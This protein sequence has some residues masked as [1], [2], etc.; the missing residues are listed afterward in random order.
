MVRTVREP[1]PTTPQL[2]RVS[3]SSAS[4]SRR[5][6]G[7]SPQQPVFMRS[8]T[9]YHASSPKGNAVTTSIVTKKR[10]ILGEREENI[11]LSSPSRVQPLKSSLKMKKTSLTPRT[12][13]SKDN[14]TPELNNDLSGLSRFI[15]KSPSTN[16][17]LPTR[18]DIPSSSPMAP[19]SSFISRPGSTPY[20]PRMSM[21][22]RVNEDD[23]LLLNM[24]APDMAFS[25]PGYDLTD[26][27]DVEAPRGGMLRRGGLMTPANSQEVPSGSPQRAQTAKKTTA[28]SNVTRN[29][30]SRL[31]TPPSSQCGSQ[32]L[33][34]PPPTPQAGPSR[35]SRI[36]AR[37]SPTPP[38]RIS[39]EP[40]EVLRLGDI[41][42]EW[43]TP[44]RLGDDVSPNP[45]RKKSPRISQPGQTPTKQR[46]PS[47]P[48]SRVEV[49]IPTRSRSNTP[50]TTNEPPATVKPRVKGRA[51]SKTPSTSRRIS[52][53][54]SRK[55]SGDSTKTTASIA[56][57]AVSRS[58][59]SIP[60]TA[61]AGRRKFTPPNTT[62]RKTRTTPPSQANRRASVPANTKT[63]KGRGRK[64]I[65]QTPKDLALSGR[66]LGMLP[67]PIHG[68]PGD[69]PLLLK[70]RYS[71]DDRREG[72]RDNAG[73]A[74]SF[75]HSSTN[76]NGHHNAIAGPSSLERIPSS[77]PF[78]F[79]QIHQQ[80]DLTL[81]PMNSN[82]NS[83]F[84]DM[85]PAWSDDGSDMEGVGEDTFIHVHQR[86]EHPASIS[87]IGESVLEEQ[88][89]EDEHVNEDKDDDDDDEEGDKTIEAEQKV[90]KNHSPLIPPRTIDEDQ[91]MS[92]DNEEVDR[93]YLEE[94]TITQESTEP[95]TPPVIPSA[96][97]M[98][99][100][101]SPLKEETERLIRAIESPH[102]GVP[103][104][105]VD[106]IPEEVELTIPQPDIV[107]TRSPSPSINKDAD[108]EAEGDITQEMQEQNWDLS[109]DNIDLSTSEIATPLHT[110]VSYKGSASPIEED[111]PENRI[112]DMTE[113]MEQ[114]NWDVIEENIQMNN[115]EN[116]APSLSSEVVQPLEPNTIAEEPPVIVSVDNTTETVE[117]EGAK[118]EEHND[119][120]FTLPRPAQD[121]VATQ[122]IASEDPPVTQSPPPVTFQQVEEVSDLEVESKINNHPANATVD[123][124][125]SR[126]LTPSSSDHS[127]ILEESE[128]IGDIT[129]DMDVLDWENSEEDI[130]PQ[131]EQGFRDYQVSSSTVNED[132]HD[133]LRQE[134]DAI[135]IV[136]SD[137]SPD[138]L[139]QQSA[140][141]NE[142]PESEVTPKSEG[143]VEEDVSENTLKEIVLQKAEAEMTNRDQSEYENNDD[144]EHLQ[145]GPIADI[146][147]GLVEKVSVTRP[148]EAI[149][150]ELAIEPETSR[151]ASPVRSASLSKSP[152]IPNI[153]LNPEEISQPLVICPVIQDEANGRSTTPLGE[154]EESNIPASPVY[155]STTPAFSPPP[156]PPPPPSTLA[157]PYEP[158]SLRSP[159]IPKSPFVL[160]HHRGDI[161]LTPR[162]TFQYIAHR[163][164]SPL[165]PPTPVFTAEERGHAILE[166]A[167]RALRR[168]SKLK[169]LSPLPPVSR[170]EEPIEFSMPEPAQSLNDDV[171]TNN[172]EENRETSH[173]DL[174]ANPSEANASGN[175][176][177][178]HE[179]DTSD[180]GN[181]ITENTSFS[182]WE[183]TTDEDG[184]VR[185]DEVEEGSTVGDNTIEANDSAWDLS[186]EEFD[187]PLKDESTG[188]EEEE[189]EEERLEQEDA[190]D[191]SQTQPEV[192]QEELEQTQE[193]ELEEEERIS[194]EPVE[195]PER[196]ILRLVEKGV[197]K[198]EP[199][200]DAEDLEED[201]AAEEE[202]EEQEEQE[203]QDI[204][205]TEGLVHSS[206]ARS[207]KNS[208]STSYIEPNTPSPDPA[209][210]HIAGPST[211]SVYPS[212]P[213]PIESPTPKIALPTVLRYANQSA[214]GGITAIERM[215]SQRTGT[216]KLSQQIL[217][218]SP[219]TDAEAESE[220]QQ[221]PSPQS[222][223]VEAQ[224]GAQEFEQGDQS[225]IVRKSRR[226]LH[227][228]LAAI[229]AVDDDNPEAD[230]SF[231]SVVEVSSLDP[232]AAARA[233]AI[234]KLNHAYI[235]HG[236]LPKASTKEIGGIATSSSSIM[237][238]STSHSDKEKRD[239]LNE[240]EL[241]IVDS[242]R[243]SRSRSRS[244]SRVPAEKE[245]PG[246]SVLRRQ[247]EMSV[248]SFMTEDY[249]VPGAFVNSPR[250]QMHKQQLKMKRKRDLVSVQE[251]S[252]EPELQNAAKEEQWGVKE[253][254][255]LETVYRKEKELWLKDRQIKNL[256]SPSS[257]P[258]S[259][260]G[261]LF[262]WARRSTF[263]S[264]SNQP[265]SKEW[266]TSRVVEN[267]LEDESAQGKK[268]DK[269][270][271]VLRVQAIERRVNRLSSS[272][273]SVT[274]TLQTP[275][276]KKT[277][278]NL[279][280]SS[281]T[282]IQT[283]QVNKPANNVEPPSTIR[284]MLGFVW[285]KSKPKADTVQERKGGNIM[286]KFE[287][288]S[289]SSSSTKAIQPSS[290]TN[291][292]KGKGKEREILPT[293]QTREVRPPV[294]AS[295]VSHP[296]S[297]SWTPIPEPP[298]PPPARVT[299][300]TSTRPKS[301][302]GPSNLI[303]SITSS[304]SSSSSSNTPNIPSIT[305]STSLPNFYSSTITSSNSK[306]LY[307]N[308]NPSLSQ[309]SNAIARLFPDTTD[310]SIR[311]SSSSSSAS[312][313]NASRSERNLKELET[314]ALQKKKSNGSVKNL[315]KNWE[316][317]GIIGHSTSKK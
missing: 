26:D 276:P 251:E 51:S 155:R 274:S 40:S 229:T 100:Y 271:L 308:L 8:K 226:T 118:E 162:P 85:G 41:T 252:V 123:F 194:P 234:L 314:I 293:S 47:A 104:Q 224:A 63:P 12:K 260:H 204:D 203:E 297:T 165:P 43:D 14:P 238:Q 22:F 13:P 168:M 71:Q 25:S 120:G 169:S 280:S 70:G 278:T 131:L 87:R 213:S 244:M 9:S 245:L 106:N 248:M 188:E 263:G 145:Q 240:A 107:S 92:P 147:E 175:L 212:L 117:D 167:E 5:S 42:A 261:G 299:T 282:S 29:P 184:V 190:T 284:R 285:G 30:I 241:E 158:R 112:G 187:V 127:P 103:N 176:L 21:P 191:T 221:S 88:E 205:P 140:P 111:E 95:A 129:Q 28:F 55:S 56:T 96:P 301:I 73:V 192:S 48:T 306:S 315:V 163:S 146:A 34:L 186:T 18:H 74:L 239:L 247:R 3:T 300:V 277:R 269:D 288:S 114:N 254:K 174:I 170:N 86:R 253:W 75:D 305:Q 177:S 152:M 16:L 101:H 97:S 242:H 4:S 298:P 66:K 126:S 154:P 268:W 232:K 113:E 98:N 207:R 216:S 121:E 115:G 311:S 67:K 304:T 202:E 257:T 182:I 83:Y 135:A 17:P 77:S 211:P 313:M 45:R 57:P 20:L 272:T 93:S 141:Q 222:P 259:V 233:A 294:P 159:S 310:T 37:P 195:V 61:P 215:L 219:S 10:A 109:S 39:T 99:Q 78:S 218:S 108:E 267:F 210:S 225:V 266:D 172:I 132:S 130:E 80:E 179:V 58:Q 292:I 79:P 183:N 2:L 125:F 76:S 143:V 275:A 116:E 166:E 223:E 217:P 69:D 19:D 235:E 296:S 255:S 161:T 150:P 303:N 122:Q 31:P 1:N 273:T 264:S 94:S 295:P 237:K 110:S 138:F 258:S 164:P 72:V 181:I 250:T 23:T 208:P 171:G 265:K 214:P 46:S 36:R 312:S 134:T 198:L 44:L 136:D 281:N 185:M 283:P 200:S 230:E 64:S 290:S 144:E 60:S 119:E 231:R 139:Q 65:A 287:A 201:G 35:A 279:G 24:T 53:G 54:S 316:D 309:R 307:P 206:P 38:R 302:P 128:Q 142:M 193:K 91:S 228:E 52:G 102:W 317:K 246:M 209:R 148:L 50:I 7:G 105:N 178:D 32:N 249:P 149:Q 156:P 270:M 173:Y 137:I 243:R 84:D 291:L 286:D 49:V 189:E 153:S 227:D 197:I 151:S 180:A 11:I 82:S 90:Q 262:S 220:P 15:A 199:E 196:I 133:E 256:P 236:V 6:S 160:I 59:R 289:S 68:S 27:S 124:D 81:L 89:Q 157:T 33:P 62:A